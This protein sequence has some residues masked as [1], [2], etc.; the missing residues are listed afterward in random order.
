MTSIEKT[1]AAFFQKRFE[2]LMSTDWLEEEIWE[3]PTKTHVLSACVRKK[4]STSPK[5]PIEQLFHMKKLG[6][7]F[8][9]LLSKTWT[10]SFFKMNFLCPVR[11]FGSCLLK[12]QFLLKFF[13][14]RAENECWS[15]QNWS[16]LGVPTESLA[17]KNSRKSM[18]KQLLGL[19]FLNQSLWDHRLYFSNFFHVS[20]I[21]CIWK[22]SK[23]N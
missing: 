18:I 3:A 16:E 13:W 4:S 11:N 1:L 10:T 7:V 17:G 20:K 2:F 5:E 22:R 19:V 21:E 23:L 15:R 9:V 12:Q 8:F 14:I 6:N